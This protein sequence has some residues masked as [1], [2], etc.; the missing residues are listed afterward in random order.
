VPILG[1]LFWSPA[2]V[3][4]HS[5]PAG[6]S[7]HTKNAGIALPSWINTSAKCQVAKQFDLLHYDCYFHGTASHPAISPSSRSAIHLLYSRSTPL[8]P[9]R[10]HSSPSF[11]ALCLLHLSSLPFHPPKLCTCPGP[12][13]R[14]PINI[15][16]KRSPCR[17]SRH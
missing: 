1:V 10:T 17:W 12:Q 2:F 15:P 7:G 4:F 16:S 13:C 11:V 5:K 3:K 6:H 14:D 8:E 9:N